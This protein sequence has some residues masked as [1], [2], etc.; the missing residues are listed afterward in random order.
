MVLLR[1]LK[2]EVILDNPGGPNAI[3]EVTA[4]KEGVR[5]VRVSAGNVR[6]EAGLERDWETP[7]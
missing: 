2:W 1:M 6:R 4:F 7:Q 3:R 5:R